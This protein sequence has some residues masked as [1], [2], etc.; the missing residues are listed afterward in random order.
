MSV[1]LLLI[2][3][4]IVFISVI[5]L[6]VEI[7]KKKP[8]KGKKVFVIGLVIALVGVVLLEFGDSNNDE[9]VSDDSAELSK[10][11]IAEDSNLN[12]GIKT[13]CM[14][15]IENN[16]EK[17][18]IAGFAPTYDWIVNLYDEDPVTDVDGSS[19]EY[20]YIVTGQYEEKG[21]GAIREFYMILGFDSVEDIED[22]HG[23]VLQ[24][25]NADTGT[26]YNIL[27]EEDDPLVKLKDM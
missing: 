4:I 11:E 19:Y 23:T 26:I 8:G 15:N 25:V 10:M 20:N 18:K 5:M 24:Y 14:T 2:G 3:I 21:S 22:G 6:G 13:L 17:Q 16:L 27:S 7:F 1:L 9:K 12:V